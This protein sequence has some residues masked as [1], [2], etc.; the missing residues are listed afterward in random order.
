MRNIAALIAGLALAV[1]A[2]GGGDDDAG[3]ADGSPLAAGGDLY[4]STCAVCHG[5]EGQG[6]VGRALDTVV[7]DFPDC[8]E[9]VRWIS[10]GSSRWE[11]EVGPTFGA[12]QTLV[13][14]GMPEYEGT[15]TDA[16]IGAVAAFTRIRFGG[17]AEAEALTDC[18]A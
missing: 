7:A 15:L 8:A 5:S 10:L 6:G 13:S 12:S 16:E 4:G 9:Q 14:G 2:W 1:A 11:D 3:S 18:G 17:Q